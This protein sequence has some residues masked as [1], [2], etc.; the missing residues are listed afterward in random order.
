MKSQVRA[1][2]ASAPSFYAGQPRGLILGGSLSWANHSCSGKDGHSHAQG[3]LFSDRGVP[4]FREDHV[5]SPIH[6]AG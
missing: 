6:T 3:T 4:V 1:R 2:G 5:L